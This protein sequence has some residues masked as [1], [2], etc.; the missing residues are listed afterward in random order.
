LSKPETPNKGRKRSQ[1]ELENEED[2]DVS[3]FKRKRNDRADVSGH[4]SPCRILQVGV[5]LKG[6]TQTEGV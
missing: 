4:T 5:K 1:V 6:G 2:K 3:L